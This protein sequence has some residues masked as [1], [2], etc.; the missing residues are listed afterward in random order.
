MVGSLAAFLNKLF[1]SRDKNENELRQQS[2]E[3]S[4]KLKAINDTNA[5]I[6]FSPN[7]NIISFN[8]KFTDIFGYTESIIGKPHQILVPDFIARS[9]KYKNFWEDLR[10]GKHKFDEFHRINIK[11]EDVYII[12]TYV[13]LKNK[14][15]DVYKVLK[16]AQDNTE[17]IKMIQE[18]E[19]KNTYLEHAAKILRHDMHS[20]INTYIP[21]GLKSLLRRI[22]PEQIKKYKLDSPI[23]MI[24]EG[25]AHTQ[26]VYKGVYEFTNLV[27]PNSTLNVEVCNI[28]E[29]LKEF[30]RPLYYRDMILIDDMPD[31]EVNQWLF[32]TGIDNL[33]RNGL[34]YND[35]KRKQVKIYSENNFII[36]EDNGRGMTPL[37]F[38]EYSKPY[39]RNYKNKESGSGLGLN[40][41]IAIMKEHG[42]EM[43]S[44]LLNNK[45]NTGTKIYIKYKLNL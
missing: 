4:L 11:G 25:L 32:C 35:S 40:I 16:I 21:R 39:V 5:I 28:S 30:L 3:I 34:K 20:G 42:F 2:E 29:I 26:K 13:P 38:E 44:K 9:K 1:K 24:S 36:I 33:I 7:S 15:G 22:T 43:S 8:Q 41:C 23:K 27:K 17:T 31:L 37:Q 10:K 19:T 6:E 45:T 12:G 14:H 18:I